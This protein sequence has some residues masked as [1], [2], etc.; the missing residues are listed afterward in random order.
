MKKGALI[1]FFIFLLLT[2]ISY[3]VPDADADGV[4]D[5]EDKCPNSIT[6]VVN[7][8]GCGCE[9]LNCPPTN[10]P[11]IEQ[12]TPVNGL[13]TCGVYND[14]PCPGGLCQRGKCIR[15]T[16]VVCIFK[17]S[18]ETEACYYRYVYEDSISDQIKG[19]SGTG[20]CGFNLTELTN[21]E[22]DVIVSSTCIG[23]YDIKT[24]GNKYDLVFNCGQGEPSPLI[25]EQVKCV[26]QQIKP[27]L[28]APGGGPVA[29]GGLTSTQ[30]YPILI[31]IN[32]S[33]VK[34]EAGKSEIVE[35]NV[36]NIPWEYVSEQELYFAID[37]SP[38]SPKTTIALQWEFLEPVPEEGYYLPPGSSKIIKMK[39]I[40]DQSSLPGKYPFTF[41]VK[42]LPSQATT[43]PYATEE[44]DVIVGKLPPKEERCYSNKGECSGVDSCIV[45]VSGEKGEKVEWKSSCGGYAYTVIDGIKEQATFYCGLPP[46]SGEKLSGSCKNPNGGTYCGFGSGTGECF[47][48]DA[49][50]QFGDCCFDYKDI[51]RQSCFELSSYPSM[52]FVKNIFDGYIVVGDKAPASD[53]IAAAKIAASLKSYEIGIDNIKLSSEIADITSVNAIVVGNACTNPAATVLLGYPQDC[54]QNLNSGYGY[55]TSYQNYGLTQILV[56]GLGD[57]ETKAASSVLINFK[58]YSGKIKGT[59]IQ[60]DA[61]TQEIQALENNCAVDSKNP[62]VLLYQPTSGKYLIEFGDGLGNFKES[63]V[64]FWPENAEVKPAWFN[65][66]VSNDNPL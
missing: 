40:V 14:K 52:F 7:Q 5:N 47:C 60:V 8:F 50:T 56:S 34:T 37:I 53:V 28:P 39:L 62:D 65:F 51:C 6:N 2:G 45:D 32:P 31:S 57:R 29:K 33:P 48:D 58:D 63:N 3:S 17:D 20:T 18:T 55:L 64:G 15:I 59:K 19:C 11:C 35:F 9:E 41:S 26:F 46:D 38:T 61:L 49:C 1:Y 16:P 27:P 25:K 4:P 10:N 13:P 22:R 42:D 54:T 30:S 24:N 36:I 23:S 21:V 66:D 43:K 12:C 44:F